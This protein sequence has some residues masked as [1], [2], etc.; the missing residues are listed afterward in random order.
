MAVAAGS[1]A[2]AGVARIDPQRH[3]VGGARAR[4]VA[5]RLLILA[6]HLD[7]KAD[8]EIV[9]RQPH[10]RE[11]PAPVHRSEVIHATRFRKIEQAIVVLSGKLLNVQAWITDAK[12][13]TMLHQLHR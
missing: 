11:I 10:V 3:A 4:S 13:E 6:A 9:P 7:L 2:G 12:Q 5:L 8:T 1:V